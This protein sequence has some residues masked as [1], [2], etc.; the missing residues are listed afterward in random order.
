[1]FAASGSASIALLSSTNGVI[2]A[3]STPWNG[4]DMSHLPASNV[5]AINSRDCQLTA[6]APPTDCIA[7]LCNSLGRAAKVNPLALSAEGVEHASKGFE[8][9]ALSR[10]RI[11]QA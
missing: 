5:D 2:S 3:G 11:T 6:S 9:E 8:K 7:A 4:S 10:W 1:M